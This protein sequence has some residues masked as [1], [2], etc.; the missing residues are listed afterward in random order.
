MKFVENGELANG[1]E[2]SRSAEK[3]V[4]EQVG[5]APC[6]QANLSVIN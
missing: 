6:N 1:A 4:V 2:N 5:S 3:P